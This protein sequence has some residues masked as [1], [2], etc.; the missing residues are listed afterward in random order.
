MKKALLTRIVMMLGAAFVTLNVTACNTTE[1]V[2]RDVEA[3][4]D[5][6]K[7]AARDAKD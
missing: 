1:G 5:N 6:L 3:A 4:G 7:D 2:G